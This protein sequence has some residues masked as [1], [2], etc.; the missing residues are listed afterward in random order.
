M[1]RPSHERTPRTLD[2]ACFMDCRYIY[3]SPVD[4]RRERIADIAFAAALGIAGA[5]LLFYWLSL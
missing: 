2:E 4:R 5:S 1:H 3:H